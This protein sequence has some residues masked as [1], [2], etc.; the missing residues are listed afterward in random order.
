[1]N[2]R[3]VY[4]VDVRE[5]PYA[6]L[7]PLS[8]SKVVVKDSFWRPRIVNLVERTLPLQY[9]FLEKTGRLDNFRVAGG[10][11]S[12]GFTGF[13]FNDSDVYKWAEASSYALVHK[14]SDGLYE[15]LVS[16]IKD[17]ADA[18]ESD[19]YINTFIK[20]RGLKRWENLAWS[21]ELYCGGHLI[22]AAVAARRSLDDAV[23]FSVARRFA[24][25][26][27][28]IF[29]YGEN[30]LKTSDGHPEIEMAL[31]ELY[32]ESRDR[33]YLDLASFFIDI[34]GRGYVTQTNRNEVFAIMMNPVYLV[35]H[36]PIKMMSDFVGS[37]AVRA[38]YFFTGATDLYLETGDQELWNAL[39]RLWRKALRKMYITG[40]FGS[41]Y[42]GEAFGEDY[43]LPNDRAYSETCASVAGV[44][45]AWRMF[46]ATGDA[47]YMDVLERVLY[48]A[49][50][51]GIS[52]D[53]TKYFYVNP[54]ADYF[55][56]HERRPWYDCACC[57]P[58]IARL[59]AYMPSII[60]AVSKSGPK[61]WVNLFVASEANIDLN[62]N[63]VRISMD[64]EYPWSGKIFIRVSPEKV[65]GFSL[66]IRIPR[67]ASGTVIKAGNKVYEPRAGEYFELNR[68]WDSG[69][70]VEVD[71][72][73][74]PILITPHPMI[75]ADW[76]KVAIVRGPLVYAIEQVDN[77]DL[78]IN[79]LAIKP[80][81]ANLR[82]RFEPQLFNGTVT[83]EGD[84]YEIEQPHKDP[85]PYHP[86]EPPKPKKKATF[87][88]IPYHLWNNRE[89]SKMHVWIKM[90]S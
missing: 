71:I 27:I 26:L 58:N 6:K 51:A 59:I 72:P 52:F 8:L 17:V 55:G 39:T 74:K 1:M 30:K 21:H 28:E 18:Q 66:M 53:G 45:W 84:G 7:L 83:I 44:M 77:K 11:R 5:S 80:S 67:W 35:D 43:E 10:K 41:R 22:Q 57:P 3:D 85:D 87:K 14:W 24:D 33:R 79:H 46:L 78:D 29:G 70:S 12:G 32:R 81:E 86:Y 49:A 62:G 61:I 50:L 36:E 42:D 64:T 65:E 47:E 34:R 13:W 37:H 63:R 20:L 4:V 2:L 90:I 31:V 54:L 23:L 69:D 89:K 60:Y 38:L 75:E 56:K 15:K 88:A 68:R 25:L 9:E 76:S 82:E 48:N 40:G 73:L 19:G 16:V